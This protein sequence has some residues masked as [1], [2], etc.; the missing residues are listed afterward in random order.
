[1]IDVKID[2]SK[3]SAEEMAAFHGDP[4]VAE[5]LATLK[6]RGRGLNITFSINFSDGRVTRS[7]PLENLS[8]AFSNKP[9]SVED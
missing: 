8:P 2:L 9:F 6:N 3:A 1:M 4:S 7:V 5:F